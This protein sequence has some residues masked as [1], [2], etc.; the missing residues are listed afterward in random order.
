MVPSVSNELDGF[1]FDPATRWYP[2]S[3]SSS[4][5]SSTPLGELRA[6]A[7]PACYLAPRPG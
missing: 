4:R 5:T 6:G 2:E 3:S 7:C 1:A